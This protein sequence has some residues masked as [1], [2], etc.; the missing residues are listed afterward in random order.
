MANIES[1]PKKIETWLSTELS[2][3]KIETINPE[4]H[5]SMANIF[6]KMLWDAKSALWNAFEQWKEAI[7]N[8]AWNAKDMVLEW[9]SGAQKWA[10]TVIKSIEE[11]ETA[12]KLTATAWSTIEGTTNMFKQSVSSVIEM[13]KAAIPEE[14]NEETVWLEASVNMQNIQDIIWLQ[15]ITNENWTWDQEAMAAQYNIINQILA[16]ENVD[17]Q[18]LDIANKSAKWFVNI[19]KELK[20]KAEKI[21]EIQQTTEDIQAEARIIELQKSKVAA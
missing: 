1:Q 21:T 6:R 20:D 18:K 2:D 12:K 16:N 19:Y 3:L 7:I 8:T 5:S 15:N 9:A 17:Y 11:T 13:W 10:E 4:V 14:L